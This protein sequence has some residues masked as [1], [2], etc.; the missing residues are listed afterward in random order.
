MYIRK[1][2]DQLKSL[3]PG[4][5]RIHCEVNSRE[6]ILKSK[7]FDKGFFILYLSRKLSDV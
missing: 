4:S 6:A 2:P 5:I 7:I 3:E 1:I